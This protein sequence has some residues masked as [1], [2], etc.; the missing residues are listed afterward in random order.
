MAYDPAAW[1]NFYI[2]TG[3]AADAL[4]GLVFV[5]M[6]LHAKTIMGNPFY[7]SRA[8]ST[9]MSL[10]TQLLLAAAVLVPGQSLTALGVEVES[11]ALGSWVARSGPSVQS[12]VV[13]TFRARCRVPGGPPSSATA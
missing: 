3:G 12:G 6:S 4:T 10:T 9:L 13:N 1:Q 8:I 11:A 5:A 7:R 2:M